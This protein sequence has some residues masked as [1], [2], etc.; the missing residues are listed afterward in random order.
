[1]QSVDLLTPEYF[2]V[3]STTVDNIAKVK[4]LLESLDGP[5]YEFD[6]IV[7]TNTKSIVE[8]LIDESET[9]VPLRQTLSDR[10]NNP[11]SNYSL[12]HGYLLVGEK[13]ESIRKA[14][15]Q[16]LPILHELRECFNESLSPILGDPLFISM[17]MFLDTLSYGYLACDEIY[18]SILMI[19]DKFESPLLA[20]KCS[21]AHLKSEFQ[22][23]FAHV[24]KFL[25]NVTPDKC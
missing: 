13:S 10:S 15:D 20:N 9:V 4:T 25:S 12:F 5:D 17:A 6:D 8:Q 11:A 22:L 21:V 3:C 14:I 19:K 2:T 18:Q 7:Y 16:M 23:L 1:M 24:N